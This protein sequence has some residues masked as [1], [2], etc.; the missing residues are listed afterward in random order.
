MQMAKKAWSLVTP[1]TIANCWKKSGIIT[2]VDNAS[3]TPIPQSLDSQAL[4]ILRAFVTT[5]MTQPEADEALEKVYGVASVDKKWDLLLKTITELEPDSDITS[6]LIEID[7]NLIQET[8]QSTATSMA[9]PKDPRLQIVENELMDHVEELRRRNRI[10]GDPLT[11]DEIIDPIEESEVGEEEGRY[12]ENAEEKI[13]QQVQ[14]ECAVRNGEI[15][16]VDDEEEELDAPPD[17]SLQ[18]LLQTCQTLQEQ[19]LTRNLDDPR[20]AE[21]GLELMEQ[22]RRFR[23][24][25]QKFSM[26]SV[27]QTQLDSFFTRK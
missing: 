17:I 6:I 18:D 5:S 26:K 21:Q 24:A 12:G 23:G 8:P 25:V 3:D 19:C 11:L 16:E 22:I 14:Y 10:H 7:S 15:I 13:V 20:L 4:A 27:Q 1:E 2:S 9:A